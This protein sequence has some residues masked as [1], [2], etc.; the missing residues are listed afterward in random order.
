MEISVVG[1]G[2]VGTTVAAC[3][4]DLGHNITNID[5]DQSTVDSINAGEAPIHEPGLDERLA[6]HGG[7]RLHATTDYDA[8]VATDLTFVALPTPANEDGSNDLSIITGGWNPSE[9]RSRRNP[10]HT[11]W[12]SKAPSFPGQRKHDSHPRCDEPAPARTS[13]SR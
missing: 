2:Y 1:S 11:S 4:A 10:T 3:L 9:R 8:I 7:Q 13:T 12:S 5:I 6:K